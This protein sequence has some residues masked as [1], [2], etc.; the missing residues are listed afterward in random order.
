MAGGE[1]CRRRARSDIGLDV[2]TEQVEE[3]ARTLRTSA[4]GLANAAQGVM[5]AV[6]TDHQ[7][8]VLKEARKALDAAA[9]F[10]AASTLDA[11]R[12]ASGY[13]AKVAG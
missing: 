13:L 9:V 12:E 6:A 8:A 10:A 11:K 5:E 7:A 3:A 1:L 4:A 2:L